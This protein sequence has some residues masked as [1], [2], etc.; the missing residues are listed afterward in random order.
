MRGDPGV[1]SEPSAGLLERVS[2][3]ATGLWDLLKRTVLRPGPALAYLAALLVLSVSLPMFRPGSAPVPSPAPPTAT[4]P[5]A[6]TEPS[7]VALLPPAI[8][9]PGEVVFRDHAAPPAPI[10]VE[11]PAAAG[12]VV[13]AL[14][15]DLTGEDLSDPAAR[16]RVAVTQRDRVVLDREC[17][18]S[19]FDRRG[20]LLM[21]IDPAT[22]VSRTP[23]LVR[24]VRIAPGNDS[25]REEVYHRAFVLAPA[26]PAR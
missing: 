8:E 26:S 17:R 9:L 23:C 12:T 3:A 14:V 20:R 19:D 25:D 6:P 15:T 16:F 1:A 5:V 22:F 18:G 2:R 11:P 10:V 13:F 7:Q 4:A 21:T 24:I